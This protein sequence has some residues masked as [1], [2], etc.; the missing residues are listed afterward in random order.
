MILYYFLED[1]T[2]HLNE[3]AYF[4]SKSIKQFTERDF[5]TE[6]KEKTVQSLLMVQKSYQHFP[7][8]Q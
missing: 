1:D 6:T 7:T 4:H 5:I 8:L 2:K 3:S